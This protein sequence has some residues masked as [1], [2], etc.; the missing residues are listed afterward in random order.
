ME[1]LVALHRID[2]PKKAV[3]LLRSLADHRSPIGWQ[4]VEEITGIHFG[5]DLPQLRLHFVHRND[6]GIA[7]YLESLA[8]ELTAVIVEGMTRAKDPLSPR[9]AE[10]CAYRITLLRMLAHI[11]RALHNQEEAVVDVGQS[12]ALKKA[13]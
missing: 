2:D 4:L 7:S 10:M 13:A 5:D 12:A 8:A 1:T 11:L 6:T 9:E 3:S